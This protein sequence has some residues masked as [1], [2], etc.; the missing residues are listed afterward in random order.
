MTTG[1]NAGT[2]GRAGGFLHRMAGP[3]SSALLFALVSV[4]SFSLALAI[5]GYVPQDTAT[6]TIGALWAMISAIV[7]MQDTR[8]ATIS[9]A[10]LRILGSLIGAIFSA[11]YLLLFPFSILGMGILI[12]LVV[13]TCELLHLPGHLRLAGLTAGIV[14]VISVVNPDIPPVVNAA[15]RFFEVIIG[16]SVAV[17]TAWIWQ[18]VFGRD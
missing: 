5:T 8:T 6:R 17:A 7:V 3:V 2:P 11:L 9:T 13:L 18:Y 12:G 15:T 1:N 10:W 14:M 16:S 4:V